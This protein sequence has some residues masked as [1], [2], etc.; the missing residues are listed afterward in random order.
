[1]REIVAHHAA[2]QAQAVGHTQVGTALQQFE[3]H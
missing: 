3:G 2:L 1:M